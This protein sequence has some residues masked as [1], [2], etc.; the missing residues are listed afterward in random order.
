MGRVAGGPEGGRGIGLPVCSCIV[1]GGLGGWWLGGPYLGSCSVTS[2]RGMVRRE[3][4]SVG[5][6]KAWLSHVGV[7]GA[8][9]G[10]H[11]CFAPT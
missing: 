5:G 6:C 3:G 2:L 8:G 1:A 7:P 11:H 9:V 10:G 4:P